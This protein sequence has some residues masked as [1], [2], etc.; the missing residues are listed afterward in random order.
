MRPAH[1]L[2]LELALPGF[3]HQHG[4]ALDPGFAVFLRLILI[5]LC[6][7]GDDVGDIDGVALLAKEMIGAGERH[8]T[9]G[10]LGALENARGTVDA[11]QFVGRRVEHQQ[12]LAQVRHAIHQRLLGDILEEFAPDAERPARQ[13]DL[14]LAL[15]ADG[16]DVLLEQAGDVRGIGR[17]GNRHHGARFGDAMR[18]REHSRATEAVA[19]QD[20][21]RLERPPQMIGGG[22]E[23]VDVRRE[24]RVG[25]IALAGA[26]PGE[27]E[28]QHRDALHRQPLG[29]PLGR[30]VVLAAGEAMREQR[31]G[32]GFAERQVEQ[33]RQFLALGVGEIETL[34]VHHCY[35]FQVGWRGCT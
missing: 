25:E 23:I 7:G 18:S 30:E 8:E 20:R 12:G 22:D 34:G 19:D 3:A 35:P 29:N 24:M 2:L 21:G 28:T 1:D 10:M 16:V 4:A 26:Q 32:A 5:T 17:R 11:D 14:D 15:R 9:L 33:R 27:I 31:E 6:P 13:Q